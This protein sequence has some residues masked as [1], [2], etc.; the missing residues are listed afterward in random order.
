MPAET[1]SSRTNPT[2]RWRTIEYRLLGL[3]LAEKAWHFYRHY[4][5]ETGYDSYWHLEIVQKTGWLHQPG[6]TELFYSYHPILGFLLAKTLTLVG[7]TPLTS[8]QIVSFGSSLAAFL[9][10]RATFRRLG[11][12]RGPKG[13]AALYLTSA[14]PIQVHLSTSVNLDVIVLAL[15]SAVLYFSVRFFWRYKSDSSTPRRKTVWLSLALV[16]CLSAAF[17][18][19]FSGLVLLALPVIIALA[20]PCGFSVRRILTAGAICAAAL[21]L[22]FPYY[23]FRYY[24]A[25]GTFIAHNSDLFIRD[26]VDGFRRDRDRHRAE[27]VHDLFTKGRVHQ[28]YGPTRHDLGRIRLYDAWR[29]FWMEDE[30]VGEMTPKAKII[31]RCY[32][33]GAFWAMLAGVLLFLIRVR[34]R[35]NWQR[36]GFVVIGFAFAECAALLDFVY[37]HPLAFW[38]PAKGIYVSPV[39]WAIGYLAATAFFWPMFFRGRCGPALRAAFALAL[40]AFVVLNHTLP[41]Y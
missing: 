24:R 29:D 12:F 11:L 6:L 32:L 22:A 38:A 19:K 8:V 36:F 4:R 18:T 21:T 35:S 34:R 7:C 30:L 41:I 25:E 9:F 27:F 26:R 40:A 31:S 33:R 1:G 14:L 5:I 20:A 37:G 17:L 13:I 10:L 23:Y 39:G 2:L 16:L 3:L 15:A 28:V